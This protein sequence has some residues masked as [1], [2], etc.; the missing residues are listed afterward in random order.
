MKRKGDM[1]MHWLRMGLVVCLWCWL[2]GTV[3]HAA[4]DPLSDQQA[5]MHTSTRGDVATHADAP[6]Y[7]IVGTVNP[8]KRTWQAT[9][10][11]TFR[12][13]SGVALNKLYFRLV[14]NLP[15]VGGTIAISTATV[16]G[17]TTPVKLESNRFLARLD[18]ATAIAPDA[19]ATV[20]LQFVTTAPNNGGTKLYGTLNYDGQTL[21][22]AT[23]YPQLA[24]L[25]NG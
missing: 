8:S 20:V 7:Q 9:Q 3:A 2:A 17:K 6:L 11:L 16:N 12:N 15:D 25:N 24:M 23:A 18:V 1:T 13:R 10:T 4:A 19:L 5:A 14:A 21:A 22:L